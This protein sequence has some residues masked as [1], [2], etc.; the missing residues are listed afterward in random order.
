MGF[1]NKQSFRRCPEIPWVYFVCLFVLSPCRTEVTIL[2]TNQQT[3]RV[4]SSFRYPFRPLGTPTEEYRKIGTAQLGPCPT[5]GGGNANIS[6]PF[7]TVPHW[8]VSQKNVPHHSVET[9]HKSMMTR[10]RDPQVHDV[11]N[12]ESLMSKRCIIRLAEAYKYLACWKSN[13]ATPHPHKHLPPRPAALD[14]Q[15]EWVHV[16]KWQ[17][18]CWGA[19]GEDSS[20]SGGVWWRAWWRDQCLWR[21]CSRR[22]EH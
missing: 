18:A 5:F 13:W 16:S 9:R 19:A 7:R 3:A 2:S 15:A 10:H 1:F 8:I 11:S 12:K 20:G 22:E 4:A 6:G 14:E 21:C 17:R